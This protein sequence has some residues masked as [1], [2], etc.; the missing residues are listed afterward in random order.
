MT[1]SESIIEWLKG[2]NSARKLERIDTDYQSATVDS[3][4]LVKEPI[5]NVKNYLS[6]KKVITSHY[7]FHARLSNVENVERIENNG[8]GEELENWVDRMNRRQQY[9]NIEDARVTDVDITTPFCIG[10]TEDN[11]AVYQ[12]TLAIQYEKE[13]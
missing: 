13:A 12:L 3:Y 5:R 1:V 4:A 7:T 10:I 11:S 9:P 8:F 2:F 6:G